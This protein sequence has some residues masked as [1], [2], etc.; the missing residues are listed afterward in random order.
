MDTTVSSSG[1]KLTIRC[2]SGTNLSVVAIATYAAARIVLQLGGPAR[3]GLAFALNPAIVIAVTLDTSDAM[4]LGLLLLS[5]FAITRRRIRWAVIA[6]TVAALTKEPS[7]LALAGIALCAQGIDRR[8]RAA[9]L[10]VPMLAVATWFAYVHWRLGTSAVQ[11]T[12]FSAPFYGYYE[13]YKAC[14]RPM[15]SWDN[16]LL[17]VL[18]L[19]IAALVVVRFW[20]RGTLLLCAAVPFALMVPFL[21]AVVLNLSTDCLRAFAPAVSFLILDYYG[22]RGSRRLTSRGAVPFPLTT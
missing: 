11:V 22:E 19:P 15:G 9:L 3:A 7:L 6:G 21:G 14:W 12:Q 16:A 5:I 10:G 20:R 8:H 2:C 17:A 13:A 1:R 4:A 18:L